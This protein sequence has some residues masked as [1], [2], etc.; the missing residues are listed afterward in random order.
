MKQSKYIRMISLVLTAALLFQIVPLNAFALET[1]L[2]TDSGDVFTELIS[3]EDTT[4]LGEIAEYR[5]ESEKHFRM[6]DGSFIAVNYGMPVHYTE[7][8]EEWID[9]DNTLILHNSSGDAVTY[10]FS[11]DGPSGYLAEN[12]DD[13]RMFADTL[14]TGFILPLIIVSKL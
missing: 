5:D 13:I 8:G 4:V 9:I 6:S 12:G 1:D 2:I 7:D 10:G 3:A 14:A 11:N